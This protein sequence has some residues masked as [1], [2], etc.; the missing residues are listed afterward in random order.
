M[1]ALL[2][3][4]GWRGKRHIPS[5]EV[6]GSTL[7][8]RRLGKVSHEMRTANERASARNR[9]RSACTFF[10]WSAG[11]IRA[12]KTEIDRMRDPLQPM[13]ATPSCAARA[14]DVQNAKDRWLASN[15]AKIMAADR[16]SECARQPACSSHSKSTYHRKKSW[17]RWKDYGDLAADGA[18]DGGRA[19]GAELL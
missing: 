4:R 10:A 13:S 16:C 12:R 14:G 5:C 17:R 11:T 6:A 18:G 3:H 7:E 19:T 15:T 8:Q 1:A 9:R 2:C